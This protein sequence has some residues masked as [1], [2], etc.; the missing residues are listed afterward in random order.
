VT[1]L[2]GRR[3]REPKTVWLW[4]PGPAESD[5]DLD[6][7]WRC[8]LRRFD[9]EHTFRFA[10]QVLGWTTPKL[11]T[12]QQADR[13]TWL[14]CATRRCCFRMEVKDRPFRRRRSGVV[15]LEAAV[16]RDVARIE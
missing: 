3:D 12:P 8:Y 13:W 9:I 4:W 10:K 16:R 15:K 14:M 11:R 5:L 6:R 1:R 2:P 7:V